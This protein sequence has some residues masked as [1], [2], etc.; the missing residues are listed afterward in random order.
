M[1]LG[2]ILLRKINVS[3][4]VG[5]VIFAAATAILHG[6]GETGCVYF[7][8]FNNIAVKNDSAGYIWGITFGMTLVHSTVDC[9]TAY[10]LAKLL[11]KRRI[12]HFVEIERWNAETEKKP[13]ENRAEQ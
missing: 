10:F 2:V 13:R 7:A 6:L 9:L 11:S 3:K 4:V 5:M 12:V 1:I 8:L